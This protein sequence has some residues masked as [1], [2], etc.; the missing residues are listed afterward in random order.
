M[1]CRPAES[2]FAPGCQ[3]V[4]QWPL[5]HSYAVCTVVQKTLSRHSPRRS[6]D[7][8]DAHKAYCKE[9]ALK[10]PEYAI[11][12]ISVVIFHIKEARSRV[13]GLVVLLLPPLRTA[14]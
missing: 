12:N 6:G 10:S 7:Y 4:N 2:I 9:T 8:P 11:S 14:R 13:A 1:A 3:G 5:P